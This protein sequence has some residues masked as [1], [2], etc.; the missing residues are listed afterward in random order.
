[1]SDQD[2]EEPSTPFSRQKGDD[3]A[4]G[5]SPEHSDAQE[6]APTGDDGQELNPPTKSHGHTLGGEGEG[7][8]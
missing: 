6:G 4:L 1:M 7:S 2:T 5:D 8:R 3:T